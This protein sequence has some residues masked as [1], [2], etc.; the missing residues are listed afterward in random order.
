[1]LSE[2][3]WVFERMKL[4]RLMKLHPE[5]SNRQYARELGHEPKWVRKWKQ[6]FETTDKTMTLTMFVSR[7]RAPKTRRISVADEMKRQIGQLREDLSKRFHRN[8]SAKTILA[9]LNKKRPQ[10]EQQG[11]FVPKSTKTINN[12]LKEMGYIT[13][14]RKHEHLPLVL[15]PPMTE[16]EMDFGQIRLSEEE[17]LEFFLVVDRGTSRVVY[18]EGC[19]G[20]NAETALEAVARLFIINGLPQRLRFDRDP[21]FVGSWTKD[22]YSSALV[23]FLRVLGVIPD[24]CPPHRPDLKPFVERKIRVLKEEWLAKFAP[25]NLADALDCLPEFL[26]YHNQDRPNFGRACQGETPN[27]AF[28]VLPPL[29]QVPETVDPDTWLTHDNQR[30]Y[31]RRVTSNGTIMIDKHVYMINDD[32]AKQSV[33]V[34]VDAKTKTF[35]IICD[36]KVV[37]RHDI[38]GLYGTQMDFGSYLVAMKAEARSIE[39]HCQ[40]LWM[41]RNEIV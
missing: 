7:S 40:L 15:P 34:H 6:R 5:W 23:R 17:W 18:I 4:Y 10:L 41:K 14:R 31:R 36:N 37:A 30:T 20:Y 26:H 27:E 22:S 29:S 1:M 2:T 24:I 33:L 3:E 13:P 16:W 39:H 11:I 38:R 25:D 9:A 12:I 19:A 8:A 32:L 35:I 21:R 28:P